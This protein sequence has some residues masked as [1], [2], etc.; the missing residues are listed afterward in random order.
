MSKNLIYLSIALL[1]MSACS[2]MSDEYVTYDPVKQAQIDDSLIQEYLTLNSIEAKKDESGLYYR[3]TVVGDSAYP[4]I[5]SQVEVKYKG[6]LLDGSI[7]DK[8]DGDETLS[9][10]LNEVIEGWQIGIPYLSIG[11]VGEFYI[12]STL[13]Y[14]PYSVGQ[15]PANSVLI[16][17][18]E[19]VDFK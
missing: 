16:F 18:V 4:T 7:F 10:S 14:G 13:G 6:Y 5:H 3:I 11:G 2:D 17:E 19:L 1:I 15:I 12:P 9:F 8:T